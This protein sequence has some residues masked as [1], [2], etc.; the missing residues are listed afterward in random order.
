MMLVLHEYFEGT[1]WTFDGPSPANV[2]QTLNFAFFLFLILVF[3]HFS[4]FENSSTV[5]DN[6]ILEWY[7]GTRF[8]FAFKQKYIVYFFHLIL[9]FPRW[10]NTD[11]GMVSFC[12]LFSVCLGADV[13][14][15]SATSHYY[16]YYQ[17]WESHLLTCACV[18]CW[19]QV[20]YTH[21]RLLIAHKCFCT[22]LKLFP[23][24]NTHHIYLHISVCEEWVATTTTLG[25]SS[26][27]L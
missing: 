18:T 22:H 1:P 23:P 2:H 6:L 11:L 19:L 8:C 16:V 24:L 3:L 14:V 15:K 4:Q 9:V 10:V 13:R 20:N 7:I 21:C 27:M 12:A 25:N 26:S 17:V 5:G